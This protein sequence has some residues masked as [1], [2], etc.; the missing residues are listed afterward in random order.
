MTRIPHYNA[1]T[2]KHATRMQDLLT[3]V[4]LCNRLGDMTSQ[5]MRCAILIKKNTFLC[6]NMKVFVTLHKS[7]D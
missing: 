4:L 5:A 7:R 2:I 3:F 1:K 6:C